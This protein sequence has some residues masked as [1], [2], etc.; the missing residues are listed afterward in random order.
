MFRIDCSLNKCITE[1]QDTTTEF[2][3]GDQINKNLRTKRKF[4]SF[5]NTKRVRGLKI[6][7]PYTIKFA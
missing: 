5:E 6:L 7:A 3:F 1:I 2:S 4:L